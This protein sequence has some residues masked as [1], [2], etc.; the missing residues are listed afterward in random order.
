MD[1]AQQIPQPADAPRL[2]ADQ[3]LAAED[4]Q[5]QLG[6]ELTDAGQRPQVVAGADLVGDHPGVTRIAFVLATAS[7]S[8]G[9]FDHQARNVDHV[10][11]G[12]SEHH[13]Q[14]PGDTAD[15]VDPDLHRAGR[16]GQAQQLI[17]QHSDLARHVV[18]A[19]A[20]H[21][22]RLAGAR[23]QAGGHSPV[24]F[25]SHVDTD[26]YVHGASSHGRGRGRGGVSLP[27]AV[28]ALPSDDP[29]RLISGQERAARQAALRPEP[30][31]TVMKAIPVPLT[32]ARSR[33]TSLAPSSPGSRP[34]PSGGLRPALTPA[35]GGA[36]SQLPEAGQNN[37]YEGRA[38]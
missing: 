37:S 25:L 31:A 3:V 38:S 17:G 19:P 10:Q 29:Q 16:R 14:Q 1:R 22:H 15:N 35:L 11:A 8:P 27:P 9:V 4:E 32:R 12:V 7:S 26:R 13:L 24:K 18:H 2:L 28:V 30:S 33:L 34:R 23:V 5:A 20:Q 6:I 36:L 21:R